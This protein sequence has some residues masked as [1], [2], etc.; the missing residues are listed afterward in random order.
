MPL[1]IKCTPTAK[2]TKVADWSEGDCG[3]DSAGDLWIRG[4]DGAVCICG[5]SI[6]TFSEDDLGDE[7]VMDPNLKVTLT[8]ERGN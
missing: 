6:N 4:F 8:I 5:G 2:A 3:Y 7:A 1:E